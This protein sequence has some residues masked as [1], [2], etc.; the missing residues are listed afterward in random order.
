MGVGM[1]GVHDAVTSRG[2]PR[3]G[4]DVLGAYLELALCLALETVNQVVYKRRSGESREQ[5]GANK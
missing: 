4:P 1:K 2:H 5:G 3:R